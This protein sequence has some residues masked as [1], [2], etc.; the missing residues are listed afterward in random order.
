MAIFSW[1]SPLF[2]P[3]YSCLPFIIQLVECIYALLAEQC[4]G[5]SSL[6]MVILYNS[7]SFLSYKFQWSCHGGRSETCMVAGRYGRRVWV[8]W[9]GVVPACRVLIDSDEAGPSGGNRALLGGILLAVTGRME[10]MDDGRWMEKHDER[11]EAEE[12]KWIKGR[13]GLVVFTVITA[14]KP[15]IMM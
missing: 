7:A 9:V 1:L 11:K 2:V 10:I 12:R 15:M 5:F 6:N 4:A 8:V 13:Y 14:S 3:C